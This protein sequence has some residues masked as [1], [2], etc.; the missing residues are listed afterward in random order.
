LRKKF[1]KISFV[2]RVHEAARTHLSNAQAALQEALPK[3]TDQGASNQQSEKPKKQDT[4]ASTQQHKEEGSRAI[5][6]LHHESEQPPQIQMQKCILEEEECSFDVDEQDIA[7]TSTSTSTSGTSS[8]SGGS[9]ALQWGDALR[10]WAQ[11]ALPLDGHKQKASTSVR[12]FTPRPPTETHKQPTS[13]EETTQGACRGPP[14]TQQPLQPLPSSQ[15]QHRAQQAEQAA[16]TV[17]ETE[18]EAEYVEEWLKG[19][20]FQDPPPSVLSIDDPPERAPETASILIG[21]TVP[22][23]R[24]DSGN[25]LCC[26]VCNIFTFSSHA[27][28]EQHIRSNR[29]QRKLQALARLKDKEVSEVLQHRPP[30]RRYVGEN[31]DVEDYVD[32]VITPELNTAVEALLTK[33]LE[34]QNRT[35]ALDPMN[36]KR[37]RR[38]VS[39]FREVEKF[40]KNGKA[41][42]IVIAPNVGRLAAVPAVSVD[43]EVVETCSK[44]K[45]A[46]S[47]DPV[48]QL[49]DV[50]QQHSI[51]IVFALSRQRLG[52][53]LGARR[54]ASAFAVLDVS[55]GEALLAQVIR[56]HSL[57]P[58][59]K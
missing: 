9:F 33:L 14:T 44:E 42:L 25:I 29:H 19:A 10:A 58:L 53:L 1:L 4:A 12:T 8:S 3:Q 32:H 11:T 47:L 37:K 41:K 16:V 27:E 20:E 31:A 56:I 2:F 36:A 55:G 18:A 15:N 21:T 39:G 26:T 5:G 7:S 34:W 54:T 17:N 28:L 23:Q 46:S 59:V 45:R 57:V 13:K 24:Q 51:P 22:L 38:V 48:N 30:Q 43:K 40:A 49:L 35:R 52:R 6:E 50:S